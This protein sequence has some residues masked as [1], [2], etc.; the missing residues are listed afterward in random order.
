MSTKKE[1]LK[2]LEDR[3]TDAKTLDDLIAVVVDLIRLEK[4]DANQS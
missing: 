2:L 4:R 1:A 3:A